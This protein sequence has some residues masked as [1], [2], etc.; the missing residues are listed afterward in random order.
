MYKVWKNTKLK[1]GG[2]FKK[3]SVSKR[4]RQLGLS[5]EA[6]EI[7]LDKLTIEDLLSLKLELAF[8]STGSR[9]KNI[10]MPLF[11]KMPLIAETAVVRFFA[12]A[13]NTR[14]EMADYLGVKNLN[15]VP[16]MLK[17][18]KADRFWNY[19]LF[20]AGWW[21]RLQIKRTKKLY[22]DF[23]KKRLDNNKGK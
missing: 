10:N 12:A 11:K 20:Y 9:E 3:F 2:D 23:E 1:S 6:F 21:T 13:S 17:K 19:K 7:M 8:F 16:E 15:G 22:E 14:K 5:N 18:Y 4:L